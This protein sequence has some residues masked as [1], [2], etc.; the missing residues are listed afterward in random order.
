MWN[1]RNVS[2]VPGL[3]EKGR[4]GNLVIHPKI[5][6]KFRK[7]KKRMARFRKVDLWGGNLPIFSKSSTPCSL[8]ATTRQYN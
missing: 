7:K 2:D 4:K 8:L 3:N 5:V 1:P 6:A